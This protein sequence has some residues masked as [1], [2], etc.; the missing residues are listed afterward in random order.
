M[1]ACRLA[2]LDV[3]DL[4]DDAKPVETATAKPA[5]K[6]KKVSWDL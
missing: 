5:K 3:M 1:R 4:V 6:K 2:Y